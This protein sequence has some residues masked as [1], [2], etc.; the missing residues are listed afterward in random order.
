[1]HRVTPLLEAK[2]DRTSFIVSFMR[3]D[4]FGEDNTRTV[5]FTKDP[6]EIM[7]WEMSK[8]T[9]WRAAGQLKYL[10]EESDPNVW[11]PEDFAAS[12]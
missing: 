4:V 7:A 9:A 12:L 2:E 8:H 10:I 6:E 11:T 5:K 1:M 3:T